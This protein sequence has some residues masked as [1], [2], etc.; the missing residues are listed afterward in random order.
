V[1][2][3]LTSGE[4][5][6]LFS[7]D[8]IPGVLDEVR[9]DAKKAGCGETQDALFAFFLERVRCGSQGVGVWRRGER[10]CEPPENTPRPSS[11]NNPQP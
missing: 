5:P 8:E 1:N 4:V 10:P 9:A 7:K 2:N 3:I 6:N 11:P